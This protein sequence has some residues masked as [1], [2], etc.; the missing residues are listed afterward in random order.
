MLKYSLFI[1]KTFKFYRKNIYVFLLEYLI[2][3]L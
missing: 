2:Q 1:E 3:C